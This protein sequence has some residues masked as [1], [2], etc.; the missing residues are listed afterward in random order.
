MGTIDFGLFDWMD[1][2][3]GSIG[4]LYESRI[5]LIELA[6]RAGFY[7]YHL[8]EHH[9]TPLGMA[10]SPAIFFAALAQRTKHIRFGPM[11]FLLP[12][13][14]PVRLIEEV[15]MLDHLSA[16]RIEVGV[17]RGVS[18][19]EMKC[20][21]V[22]PDP[23]ITREIFAETLEIFRA[24][25]CNDVLDHNGKYFQFHDVPMEIKPLQR[26][27]PPLWYPSFSES[28][29]TY[30][31]EHGF[32]FLSLG[33][34]ALVTQLMKIYREVSAARTKGSDRI[35]GHV[36]TPKLGAMRQI[37]IAETD[38]EAIKI[39]RPAYEDW[40]KSITKLWHRNSDASYDDFFRWDPCFAGETILVGSVAKICEQIQRVVSES[41]INYFVG[42]FAWGSLT[43]EQSR[44]SLELFISEIVPA[45]HAGE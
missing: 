8:A 42:S 7:G 20:F 11:A 45:I 38:E 14:H 17:S 35:N 4:D 1:H 9:G 37:Y 29:A 21:S 13:Y 2:G 18:P 5:K 23:N 16:G 22:E 25:M 39:A 43:P 40:Y 36:E 19:Y 32:N 30:A 31:A 33:P 12:L 6:D 28:G 26:P 24:G 10:P 41:G 34:P 15:C 3:P 27:Y 44:R